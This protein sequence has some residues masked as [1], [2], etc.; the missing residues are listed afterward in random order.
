V[1]PRPRWDRPPV[2]AFRE[3]LQEEQTRQA[4]A[5]RGFPFNE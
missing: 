3:L 4:L 1:V 5:A 2:R